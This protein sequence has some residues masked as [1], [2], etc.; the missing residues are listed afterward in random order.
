[1]RFGK[2][3][4]MG[5]GHCGGH[6]FIKEALEQLDLSQEQQDKIQKL[7]KVAMK[8][9]LKLSVKFMCGKANHETMFNMFI[10]KIETAEN[11]LNEEQKAKLREIM[12]EKHKEMFVHHILMMKDN[13]KEL[14]EELE[15]NE[16][17]KNRVE[18]LLTQ[19]IENENIEELFMAKKEIKAMLSDEQKEKVHEYMKAHTPL[20]KIAKELEITDEQKEKFKAIHEEACESKLELIKKFKAGEISFADMARKKAAFF[21]E[22]KSVLSEEQI[23][24]AKALHRGSC[25]GHH[26]HHGHKHH[27]QKEC[28]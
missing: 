1:M 18:T 17:Q 4:G 9:K 15:L 5:H 16:E 26:K 27:G 24:K 25:H 3:H 13:I 14:I 11:I 20:G 8:D 23:K 6:K 10:E 22:M 21:K 12:I 7:K 2:M 19:A 28:C